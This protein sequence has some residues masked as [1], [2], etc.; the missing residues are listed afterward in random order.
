MRLPARILSGLAALGLAAGSAFAA[1]PAAAAADCWG[2]SSSPSWSWHGHSFTPSWSYHPSTFTPSVDVDCY[3]GWGFT[4]SWS[5]DCDHAFT[6]SWSYDCGHTWD[7]CCDCG[8]VDDGGNGDDSNVPT[9]AQPY[10][11]ASTS[12]SPIGNLLWSYGN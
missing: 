10:S 2:Y 7:C 9:P 12:A 11:S 4:P 3:H 5:Y 8:T 6:P 1:A